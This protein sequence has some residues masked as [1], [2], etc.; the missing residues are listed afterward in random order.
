MLKKYKITYIA[1]S[2]RQREVVI[3]ATSKYDAKQRFYRINPKYDIVRVE[4]DINNTNEER[5]TKK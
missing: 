4:E 5:N 3:E 2:K 1:L